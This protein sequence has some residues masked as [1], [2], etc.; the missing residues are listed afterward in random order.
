MTISEIAYELYKQDWINEHLT[1]KEILNTYREY[2]IY[3]IESLEE[4]GECDSFEEWLWDVGY[5]NGC[6]YVCY[7]EFCDME[8]HDKEYMIELL[9]DE[10]LIQMYY[11]D[12]NNDDEEE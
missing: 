10:T 11:A 2:F 6:M 3:R 7:E 12:I 5:G 8:Y 9:Q 1:S 4:F